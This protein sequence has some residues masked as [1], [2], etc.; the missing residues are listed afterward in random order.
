MAPAVLCYHL[1]VNVLW[2]ES[3]HWELL[4]L[5]P[6]RGTMGSEDVGDSVVLLGK[7]PNCFL[8]GNRFRLDVRKI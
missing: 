5:L 7:R 8:E 6:A 4:L 1:R 2:Q 3:F